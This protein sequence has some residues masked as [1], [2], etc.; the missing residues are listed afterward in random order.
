MAAQKKPVD[1]A[2]DNSAAVNVEEILKP[3]QDASAK[4]LQAKI[5]SHEAAAKQRAQACIDLQNRVREVEQEVYRAVMDATKKQV[6][7]IGQQQAG[8]VEEIYFA[9][10]RAQID[11][12]REVRQV[13]IEAHA[14]LAA[15]GQKA[16]AED[17]GGTVK[18]FTDQR[19]DAYQT[20]LTDL[21]Q[22][23]STTKSLDP[24]T[25]GAIASNMM[26]A[27]HSG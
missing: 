9:R 5:A 26:Y 4:F 19:Q 11:F 25:M 15:I 6:E 16:M 14:K 8:S 13:Y 22:A 7:Q 17:A 24:Q 27:M 2:P 10:A 20:Y 3:F 21:Q 1:R 23:W 12:E 18:G